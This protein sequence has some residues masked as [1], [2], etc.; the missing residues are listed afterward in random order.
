M[1]VPSE[2]SKKCPKF[3]I[4]QFKEKCL[5]NIAANLTLNTM[6]SFI[7]LLI[8]RTARIACA[9]R[10]TD[11]QTHTQDNH[12]NPRCTC[13]PRVKY[14]YSAVVIIVKS[15]IC[16]LSDHDLRPVHNMT[17]VPTL[18]CV[19][20]QIVNTFSHLSL[21]HNI[22]WR[23]RRVANVASVTGETRCCRSQFS[24]R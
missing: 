1:V 15:T 6:V 16:A 20:C 4:R 5:F 23:Q 22:R 24:V 3:R 18:R 19:E 2:V 7:I 17:L 21:V 11:T 9:D 13:V 8:A 12:C 10:H 14:I